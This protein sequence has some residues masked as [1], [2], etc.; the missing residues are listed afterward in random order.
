MEL[1]KVNIDRD[2][3]NVSNVMESSSTLLARRKERL[4]AKTDKIRSA[5]KMTHL[6]KYLIPA[7]RSNSD[8]GNKVIVF[9]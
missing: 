3:Q 8:L 5:K 6:L 9:R 1:T 7:K 4:E 2:F